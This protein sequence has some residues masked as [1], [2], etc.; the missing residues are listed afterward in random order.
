[1]ER[2][3][4]LVVLQCTVSCG[5]ESCFI[6]T[7]GPLDHP[8][9]QFFV[10]SQDKDPTY[11]TLFDNRSGLTQWVFLKWPD[12]NSPV[13]FKLAHIVLSGDV[14]T[15]KGSYNP[16]FRVFQVWKKEMYIYIYKYIL[17]WIYIFISTQMFGINRYM[18]G[19]SDFL[20]GVASALG[21][22]HM[23]ISQ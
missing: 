14:K 17:I 23:I 1:M 2:G 12:F 10:C 13:F 9:G 4:R 5:K 22:I 18:I 15:K 11:L 16:S 7:E 20:V 3:K 8:V 6:W 19:S 21:R